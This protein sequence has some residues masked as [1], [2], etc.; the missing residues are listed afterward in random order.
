[1]SESPVFYPFPLML[2]IRTQEFDFRLDF[3]Q[4][5]GKKLS[6]DLF[7]MLNSPDAALSPFLGISLSTSLFLFHKHNHGVAQEQELKKAVLNSIDE[8][9][10]RDRL[11][12]NF[13]DYN[14]IGPRLIKQ[15]ATLLSQYIIVFGESPVSDGERRKILSKLK[16]TMSSE[17]EGNIT[18]AAVSAAYY[19]TIGGEV[20]WNVESTSEL[21]VGLQYRLLGEWDRYEPKDG[22]KEGLAVAAFAYKVLRTSA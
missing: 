17:F 5:E 16:K 18:S 12:S 19:L 14:M 1:M 10:L 7:N 9:L 22:F 6:D 2:G 8:I 21:L 3:G 15:A 4:S 11:Y 20:Y 13:S